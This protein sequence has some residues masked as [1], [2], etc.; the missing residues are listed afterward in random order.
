MSIMFFAVK[1]RINEIGIKKALG[2]TSLDILNQFITEGIFM[3]LIAAIMSVT[4]G[5]VF[6]IALQGYLTEFLYISF[7]AH[8][9]IRNVV[10]PLLVAVIYGFIF[11]IIPSVYGARFK[12]TESLRFE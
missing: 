12:I 1:E 10:T 7:E 6:T 4:L 2:A 8:I 11:S 5:I 9:N 3:A